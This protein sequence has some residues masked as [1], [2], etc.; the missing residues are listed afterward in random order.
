MTTNFKLLAVEKEKARAAEERAV[1]KEAEISRAYQYLQDS[2]S[3]L[4]LEYE[5][6]KKKT[7]ALI[8]DLERL[9]VMN[10]KLKEQNSAQADIIKEDERRLEEVSTEHERVK[11]AYDF[12]QIQ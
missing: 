3:A 12:L 2:Y 11:G 10:N 4:G 6:S 1:G 8:S 9:K 5:E 7:V